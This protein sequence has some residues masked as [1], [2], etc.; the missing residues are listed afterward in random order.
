MSRLLESASVQGPA[1]LEKAF[2]PV[3][4][5]LG[6]PKWAGLVHLSILSC[7]ASFLLQRISHVLGPHLFPNTYPKIKR[8]QDDWDLHVYSK[9]TTFYVGWVFAL[10]ATPFA[11]DLIRHPSAAIVLDRAYGFGIAEARLNAFATGYFIWDAIVSAQHISTQGLGFFL[12]GFGCML[13]FLFTLKPF[14]LF[15]G[16]NFLIWELSTI[17]LN[18]H[19]YLDKFGLTGSTLQLVNGIFLVGAYVGARLIWG[20]YNSYQ[21]WML[22]FG[23]KADPRAGNVRYLYCGLN[24]LMNS[25]NFFWFRAMVL[26]LKKRFVKAEPGARHERIEINGKLSSGSTTATAEKKRGTK[27]E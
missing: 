14:L 1:G 15:C 7:A 27:R 16:P 22:F 20:T 2:Q 11:F 25:L 3:A 9:Y 24:L 13:A 18:A 17:F 12:H 23:P 6:V 21:L 26:A 5:A 8:K 19:W 10:I 4:N